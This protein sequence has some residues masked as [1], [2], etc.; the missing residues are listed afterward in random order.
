MTFSQAC[1]RTAVRGLN[2]GG[3][4][5][6]RLGVHTPSLDTEALH[7]AA[8]RR[9]GSSNYGSWDFAE[10]LERLL[11]SYRDEAAL[12]T[13]GRITARELIVSLLDNLLRM[14]AER[15]ANL[16]IERQRIAAPVFIVG[17]PRTGTTHLHGLVSEDPAN[18]A[19]LTW[20]VMY[21][22]ASR[23]GDEIARA[24]AQ[25]DARL[26]W[27][28]RFA[29]EFMRIHPI[30]ADL[31]Q[32]C[33]AITAQVFMSI[34]FHTTHDV[35][36]YQNWLE[37]APQRLGFDF[38]HRFLQHLQAK[39][40]AAMDGG[41][42]ANAGRDFPRGARWVL[43]APGHLFA[44]EGLLERYP[45]ARIIHTHRDPLRVMASMASHATVLR[46]AFSDS[47]DPRKIAADWADRW[48]RALEKFLAIRDRAPA[49]QFLDINFESIESDALDTVERVY[50][51][52]GWPL[53]TDARAA[54]QK[55]LAAN[56][57]NKHGV[58]SYTLEQFGL[59][60]AAE[61]LRFRNYCERFR[62]PV[63]ADR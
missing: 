23:A 12:T 55:F 49:S 5:L 50:D 38:H 13:L 28:D 48:A 33:I 2:L 32:E 41:S 29:P 34:Q 21:P 36:S 14:E 47:A 26:G 54:M 1:V 57:K 22:A 61:L 17:L 8:Y 7:R 58:H 53:T 20:E 42:A 4:T 11:K 3:R 63:R 16:E 46:R 6:R 43:K 59:S 30:A 24:R 56:P 45:D 62:I 44:L 39:S 25:T 18:R 15:A 40:A 9:A 19:P 51:F 10:P 52:L 60:R 35:P 27:A 31:P 37:D